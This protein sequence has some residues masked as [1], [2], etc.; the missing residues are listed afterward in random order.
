MRHGLMYQG[1]YEQNYDRL[2]A[3]TTTFL[4]TDGSERPL[5]SWPS[6]VDGIKVGY[7]ER[8]GKKFAAVRVQFEDH[9]LVL[10]NP[11]LLD[12]HRHMAGKR[13]AA[14]PTVID[15]DSASTL[16]DDAIRQNPE[17]TNELARL[18]NRVNQVRRGNAPR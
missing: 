7:M 1:S 2:R 18:I 5:H 17:Q 15:D 16:L 13:F 8:S 9:D 14:E 11:V 4:G 10:Q 3:G 12:P 6:E